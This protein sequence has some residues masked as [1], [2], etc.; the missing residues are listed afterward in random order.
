M[1]KYK[2]SGYGTELM[3]YGMGGGASVPVA[4]PGRPG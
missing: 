1:V 3:G 4:T 2:M